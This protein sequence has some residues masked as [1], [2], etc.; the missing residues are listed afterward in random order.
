MDSFYITLLSS[1]SMNYFPTNTLASFTN[2][3]N[4]PYVLNDNWYVGICHLYYNSFE[5]LLKNELLYIYTDIIEPNQVG[6][7]QI[8][9]LRIINTIHGSDND[10]EFKK[11]HYLPIEKMQ[12]ENISILLT[13]GKGE[14]IAFGDS[15]QPTVVKL[16]FSKKKCIKERN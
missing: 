8:R 2:Q 5:N 11:I 13:N 4:K 16:H 3:F 7:S 6:F 15:I 12:F 10:I 1:D 14:K 9:C